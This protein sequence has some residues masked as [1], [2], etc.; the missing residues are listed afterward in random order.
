MVESLLA[1]GDSQAP[2]SIA[3]EA[4]K[5][6]LA[7][8]LLQEIR[9]RRVRPGQDLISQIVSSEIGRSLSDDAIMYNCRQ[10]LFAG[11]ETTSRWLAQA[12]YV[13]GT[14]PGDLRTVSADHSLV[15]AMMEEVM[16]WDAVAQMLPR[17][18]RGAALELDGV[19]VPAG[20]DVLLLIGAAN[21]D[22]RRYENPAAFDIHRAEKGHL[23]FGFGLHHCL[24]ATLARL[25]TSIAMPRFLKI[26]ADYVIDGEIHYSNPMARSPDAVPIRLQ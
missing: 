10:L 17:R 9:R 4:A 16:R 21:R 22:A 14:H 12:T 25:E 5:Q 1:Q 15:P 3:A 19:S 11:N 8:F 2:A 18:V 20:Q 23:G 13:L 26:A 6:S 7:D 24:G